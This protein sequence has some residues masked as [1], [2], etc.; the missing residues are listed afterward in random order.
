MKKVEFA[1]S[2]S[3]AN[4]PDHQTPKQDPE[5]DEES[6]DS[7]SQAEH[8]HPNIMNWRAIANAAKSQEEDDEETQKPNTCLK[9]LYIFDE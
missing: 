2:N 9:Y 4:S 8:A 3:S 1:K 5:K 7:S 6:S